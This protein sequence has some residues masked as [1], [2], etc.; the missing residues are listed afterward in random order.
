MSK[1]KNFEKFKPVCLTSFMGGIGEPVS[2][3]GW[4]I[5]KT[6]GGSGAFGDFSSDELGYRNGRL[7]Y[8]QINY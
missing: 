8:M 3:G 6:E 2:D 4:D 1:L 7:F 5:Q